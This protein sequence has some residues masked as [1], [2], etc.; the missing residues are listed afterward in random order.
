M[1]FCARIRRNDMKTMRRFGL[2]ILCVLLMLSMAF[3]LA[4]CNGNADQNNDNSSGNGN[5]DNGT[6]DNGNSSGD[7]TDNGGLPDGQAE[8][9]V[10]VIDQNG[11]PVSDVGVQLCSDAG[12]QMPD[13]TNASGKVTFTTAE[14]EYK[15]QIANV[16]T[17]YIAPP[18]DR[19]FPLLNNCAIITVEKAASYVVTVKD[20]FGNAVKG[21][22]V[23]HTGTN[24]GV[25]TDSTGMAIF[26]CAE[27]AGY[28]VFVT[29]PDG[30]EAPNAV[31]TFNANDK[32]LNVTVN[33]ITVVTV[34]VE[35]ANGNK[36]EGAVVAVTKS[37]STDALAYGKSAANG[38]ARLS[39]VDAGASAYTAVLV[40]LDGY[41]LSA[42]VDVVDGYATLKLDVAVTNA[43]VG[44]VETPAID[45]PE[46]EI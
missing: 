16:P 13:A 37:G 19:K 43:S 1:R 23:T 45:W 31:F 36:L 38:V 2:L 22:T 15:A 41:T 26:D 42:P 39:I 25:A 11:A 40:Y 9:T 10:L 4:A 20:Q 27:N 14:D 30:Y 34:I 17:G 3:T 7:N 28:N 12:C 8:Y 21:A 33:K 29:V 44:G 5:T 35:D 46:G 18:S 6:N 24:T 32:T